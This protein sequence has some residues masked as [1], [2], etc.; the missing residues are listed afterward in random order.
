M[1]AK[2]ETGSI[3]T[4]RLFD[5]V[6]HESLWLDRAGYYVRVAAVAVA[7]AAVVYHVRG[8]YSRRFSIKGRGEST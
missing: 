5:F 3:V 6:S 1:R 7:V 4:K 8:M 2:S